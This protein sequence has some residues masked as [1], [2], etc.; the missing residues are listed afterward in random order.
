MHKTCAWIVGILDQDRDRIPDGAEKERTSIALPCMRRSNRLILN[1]LLTT[2]L[3]AV[4][5][6]ELQIL[7]LRG[8]SYV[9]PGAS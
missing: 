4:P 2:R 6:T 9:L 7:Q 1:S 8:K 3:A 5:V